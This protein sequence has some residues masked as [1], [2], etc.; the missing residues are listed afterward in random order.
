MIRHINAY[1]RAV[2]SIKADIFQM[3]KMVSNSL[4]NALE[5]LAQQDMGLAQKVILG[6]DKIDD[7]DY[8]IEN[9]A[10]ELIALQQPSTRDLRVLSSALRLTKELERI[11]DY[12]VNIAETARI[13]AGQREYFKPLI[14]IGRMGTLAMSM[15]E[16][17]L[18]AYVEGDLQ[19]AK[20]VMLADD[21]VDE[22]FNHLFT[23]L[24]NIMKTREE[25][26][27]QAMY[28]SL[29]ARYLERVGDHSVNLA[30][31]V[32]YMIKGD[33]RPFRGHRPSPA[34]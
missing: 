18:E 9:K 23:E 33:R 30:E 28:L 16:K 1:D 6:D 13:L 14:D 24:L 2:Q 29:V 20:E 26:V 12:A 5:A 3:G 25:H 21:R 10:L 8:D 32:F 11:G 27:D 7:M 15:L 31:M 17:G 22:L 34:D 19:K 4:K